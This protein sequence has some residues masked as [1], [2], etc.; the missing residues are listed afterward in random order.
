MPTQLLFNPFPGLRLTRA[1]HAAMYFAQ[2]NN[3]GLSI[4]IKPSRDKTETLHLKV[5][6]HF[7][8]ESPQ[9]ETVLKD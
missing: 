4:L 8:P 7:S 6:Q 2:L 9:R 3:Q 1:A 5:I